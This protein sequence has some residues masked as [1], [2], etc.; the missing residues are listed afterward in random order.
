LSNF[1]Y[2]IGHLTIDEIF[3]GQELIRRIGGTAYYSSISA[4]IL[5]WNCKLISKVGRDFPEDYLK[6]LNSIGLDVSRVK[7]SDFPSTSFILRYGDGR[8]LFLKSRCE[9]IFIDD[10]R[11]AVSGDAVFHIGSVIGEVSPEIVNY[12]SSSGVKM[13][14]IDLQ[15]FLRF[16]DSKGLIR[17]VK[18]IFIDELLSNVDLVHCDGVEASV[19]TGIGNPV[20]AAMHM[21]NTYDVIVLLTLGGEG[22]YIFHHGEAH[23]IPSIV[24]CVEEETGAGDIYVSAFLYRY[25]SSGRLLESAI[26][27]SSVVSVYVE[28]GDI[29]RL[30]DH[31]LIDS[32]MN[33][34]W[35]HVKHL[36]L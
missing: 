8:V 17:L 10:V 5:G 12:I 29:F 31:N 15:G 25:I 32:K 22:S 27:S 23:Y 21:C 1:L 35:G 19:A 33:E 18:P 20:E 26:Y 2:V 3:R 4:K 34:L 30:R 28:S 16:F 11:E 14:S 9:D 36:P 24:K 7:F 6:Y 13:V